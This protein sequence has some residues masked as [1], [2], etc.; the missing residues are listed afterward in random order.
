MKKLIL[1]FLILTCNKLFAQKFTGTVLN[2]KTGVAIEKVTVK[3][4]LTGEIE[5]TN[6]NG[7]FGFD[8]VQFPL[9][10]EFRLS[11]YLQA[12]LKFE[13]DQKELKIYLQQEID[14]LSEVLIRSSNIP[15]EI[16]KIPASV[17]LISEN[18]LKRNDNFNLVQNFNYV[19]GVF[20][21][22]GAL[23]TNKINIRG[24]GAR[25]QYSTNRI[26][27]YINGIPLTTA[28]GEL[29]LDDF[30]PE[31]LD[32]IEIFKGP[33]SSVFG[34]GLGGSIN[35]FTERNLRDQ[36]S[37][38]AEFNYGS[39][40][41]RKTRANL[42][43]VKDSLDISI[44]YNQVQSDGYRQNGEYDRVSV[45]GSAGLLNKSGNYWSFFFSYTNLKAYIP[46]SLSEE[47]FRNDPEKAA[48]TWNQAAGYES[49]DKN[50]FGISYEHN[51][52][53]DLKNQ[54]SVFYNARD[55][56]EPRPFDILDE[57]RSSVGTRTKF[58]YK[59]SIF[60]KSSELSFGA[61]TMFEFY[62][63]GTF[64]NLY[65]KVEER[66]SIQGDRLSLNEQNRNYI[67]VFAQM[68]MELTSRL[69]LE[70]GL[71]FNSTAYDLEDRF[72]S[73]TNDQSGDY[74][75]D[76]VLSPRLGLSY[77]AFQ[78]K[79]FY[80]SASHG[81]ST[82]TVAETLTPEGLINTD[83]KTETGWNYEIGF[84]GNWLNNK[85]YTELNLYSIQI[86]NLLV[87][88]RVGQDQ[89]VGVNAGKADH[90][91]IE[92]TSAYQTRVSESLQLKLFLNSNFNFFEFD[93]FVDQGENYS[94][95]TIPG[96][97]EHMVSP[98]VEIGLKEFTA[99]VNF[100]AFGK[101]ALNDD[102]SGYTDPYELLN[103]KLNY[104]WDIS[105]SL[106]L[107]FNF[108]INNILNEQYAASIVTNAVGFGGSAP[109]YY[110]PGNPRNYF[111]GLSFDFD[112]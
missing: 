21:S 83:L 77:E 43:Y 12:S 99:N 36:R 66:K 30:D 106:D 31:Y 52:S 87:A 35:L 47:D 13:E 91:G 85:L 50:I 14:Q 40:N 42:K 6:E 80:A 7:E 86:R 20:V 41:T 61:E 102:N 84:K 73:G 33:V 109:R 111:G 78:G 23:N 9:E 57:N 103:L 1:L 17:S 68:N 54:T 38:I 48:F 44:N 63:T 92:F 51:F 101:M 64:E 49:Y 97:P 16:R 72:N 98:G 11:G 60:E 18:D 93:K 10:L 2:N 59:T 39:F 62:E 8:S 76:P 110:Y 94:G 65:E 112:F 32:R 95:N 56:Y 27:A 15:Q 79:N 53:S 24:I 70:A 108:G 25:S 107:E 88:R 19:P 4:L 34:A 5:Y 90:N 71:N 28:E 37:V 69:L 45:L 58:N 104:N 96:V 82:P 55:G 26:K 75:F 74:S 29:T 100:Q 81:F 22:Q 67:N 46:S 3:N 89:Y 105:Q